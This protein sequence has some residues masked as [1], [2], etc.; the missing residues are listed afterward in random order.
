MLPLAEL[1]FPAMLLPPTA[2]SPFMIHCCLPCEQHRHFFLPPASLSPPAGP[3]P[4]VICFHLPRH[5]LSHCHRSPSTVI[6]GITATAHL[7]MLPPSPLAACRR[8]LPRQPWCAVCRTAARRHCINAKGE[9]DGEEP[10]CPALFG[11]FPQI[12]KPSSW[13]PY[14]FIACLLFP[15]VPLHVSVEAWDS[16]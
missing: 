4:F 15:Y 14:K 13:L 6:R 11:R 12:R 16:I 9:G 5:C 3:P 2:P 8:C 1:S 10:T 7:C